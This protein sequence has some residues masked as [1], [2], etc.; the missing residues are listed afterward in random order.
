MAIFEISPK[1]PNTEDESAP[2]RPLDN[3]ER[4]EFMPVLLQQAHDEL[5][6][7]RVREAFWISVVIHMVFIFALALSPKW[8][9]GYRPVTVATA[10]DLLQDKDLTY[11][12]LP[13]DEQKVTAKPNTKIISD[14]DRV[15]TSRTPQI[16]RKTLQELRDSAANRR[17]GPPNP[18]GAQSSQAQA[19]QPQAGQQQGAPGGQQSPIP[20]STNSNS[21]TTAQ[22]AAPAVKP[23]PFSG[24]QSAGTII[25]EAARN[26]RAGYGGA[27]G[28][29]GTSP[30]SSGGIKSNM[31][32]LSDTQGVDFGPYLSRVLQSVRVNWY[33]LIPEVARPPIMK[34]GKVSIEFVILKDGKVAGMR[35]VGPSGDVALDRAAWGGITGSNP[36]S[37]LPGEFR[38]PYL[39]LRFHFF[40][41]PD[42]ADLE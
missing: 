13:S 41:N 18:P 5:A 15:A 25:A 10:E 35:V 34:K 14:K 16:D 20:P 39:A 2:E 37:P 11:L 6:R 3:Q 33:N 12:Q 19:A 31:D 36:F 4:V 7:S 17:P 8:L 27:G 40:Y 1:T 9:P 29:Y 22:L 32:V 21:S 24:A 38:G 28:D 30:R 23:N 26:S 42:K